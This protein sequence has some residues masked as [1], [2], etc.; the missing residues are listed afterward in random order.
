MLSKEE[1]NFNMNYFAPAEENT[2]DSVTVEG[3]RALLS[4]LASLMVPA[5]DV[6]DVELSREEDK[7]DANKDQ[8]VK[9]MC[10]V[11]TYSEA[12]PREDGSEPLSDGD[13][14][15]SSVRLVSEFNGSVRN[16]ITVNPSF[17][18]SKIN[19]SLECHEQSEETCTVPSTPLKGQALDQ[20]QLISAIG[21][22]E[23]H[24][25]AVCAETIRP[26]RPRRRCTVVT[27]PG[28]PF[29]HHGSSGRWPSAAST[30][31]P[32]DLSGGS[33]SPEGSFDASTSHTSSSS[34]SAAA[35]SSAAADAGGD[36]K[37]C[38]AELEASQ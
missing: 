25:C 19:T 20:T 7:P 27:G 23:E 30:Q 5:G 24:E 22:M 36:E 3:K 6:E 17:Q 26:S 4:Y 34:S 9:N 1:M 16:E 8:R 10:K 14:S 35:A 12:A 29:L 18:D 38:N 2:V 11:D 13:M 33:N 37:L 28:H 21:A 31:P 15:R 32:G